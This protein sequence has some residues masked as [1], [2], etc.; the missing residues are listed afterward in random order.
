MRFRSLGFC[1]AIVLHLLMAGCGAPAKKD[2]SDLEGRWRNVRATIYFSDGTSSTP[3]QTRCWIEFSGKRSVSECAA[4]TGTNRIVYAYRS[5]GPQKYETEVVEH[6][7]LPHLVGTRVRTDFRIE[8]GTLFT[9]SYP[10]APPGAS[11]FAIKTESTW[12]RE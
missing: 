7:N 3:T 9:T 5:L 8:N 11:R 4:N 1:S 6:K 10:P 12:V 2:A